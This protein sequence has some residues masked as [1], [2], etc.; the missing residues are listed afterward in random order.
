MNLKDFRVKWKRI[1]KIGK[2]V[3]GMSDYR[4]DD[5]AFNDFY[6]DFRDLIPEDA[7]KSKFPEYNSSDEDAER[8][9]SIVLETA[10]IPQR[11]CLDIVTESSDSDLESI[12]GEAES[13][14]EKKLP[15]LV[16]SIEPK[17]D[18]AR[19]KNFSKKVEVYRDVAKPL[20]GENPDID[21]IQK[22]LKEDL[23]KRIGNNP[24]R[25]T[26]MIADLFEKLY[27]DNPKLAMAA[28]DLEF[29]KPEKDALKQAIESSGTWKTYMA[30]N[31]Q[32]LKKPERTAFYSALYGLVK[33]D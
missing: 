32:E 28:Y 18:Y 30:K 14:L 24:D 1:E 15:E 29:V 33:E 7:R 3:K 20:Q 6:S 13:E 4:E 2:A 23:K 31:I 26:K 19:I 16:A 12:L 9:K 10:S 17:S 21:K 22:K 8:I 25:E 5:E 11:A 27:D